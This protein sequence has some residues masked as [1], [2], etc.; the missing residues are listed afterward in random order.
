MRRLHDAW[1]SSQRDIKTALIDLP[2]AVDESTVRFFRNEIARLS[3]T[4]EGWGGDKTAD[5][6]IRRSMALYDR[7]YGLFGTFR[8]RI[9]EGTIDGGYPAL[10]EAYNRA[11]ASPPEESIAALEGTLKGGGPA[12]SPNGAVGIYLFGNVLPD[13]EAFRLFESCG[14]R[15]LSDDICTGSRLFNPMNPGDGEDALLDLARGLLARP[16]CA[17]TFNAQSP[18][19]LAGEILRG[20]KASGARGVIG[21][22]AKFCDPYIA[23]V[24][25]IRDA[26]RGAGI[27]FLLLEGDC[28]LRSIGQ[29]RTRIEA[30]IEMVR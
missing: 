30:F 22:T 4:L 1:S 25:G 27:P 3:V 7:L 2:S 19:D 26:L 29:Q 6:D 10:Q 21:Y 15:I 23:R 8:R 28:T 12:G 16:K 11:S 5:A 24:P 18:G 13:P 14:A 17:R 9:K 20:A